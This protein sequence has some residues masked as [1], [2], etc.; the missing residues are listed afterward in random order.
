MAIQFS[1][2]LSM[3]YVCYNKTE[4]SSGSGGTAIRYSNE[5]DWLSGS[6]DLVKWW[7]N[8]H[9][10]KFQRSNFFMQHMARVA[11]STIKPFINKNKIMGYVSPQICLWHSVYNIITINATCIL[12]DLKRPA[13]YAFLNCIRHFLCHLWQILSKVIFLAKPGFKQKAFSTLTWVGC[14][15]KKDRIRSWKEWK[16][17]DHVNTI[18]IQTNSIQKCYDGDEKLC[19][20]NIQRLFV[21]HTFIT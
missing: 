9:H 18:M 15:D 14:I 13:A 4:R 6:G 8:K 7:P 3:L 20:R 17:H 10:T 19:K 12:W 11:S 2:N 21:R 1:S 16:S 5:F